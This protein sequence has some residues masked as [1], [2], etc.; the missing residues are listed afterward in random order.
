MLSEITPGSRIG[1]HRMRKDH[2]DNEWVTHCSRMDK[3][4]GKQNKIQNEFI[5]RYSKNKIFQNLIFL[6]GFLAQT[7]KP[8]S[9]NGRSSSG[10]Y[11]E[12]TGNG[13]KFNTP[14]R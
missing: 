11:S 5:K 9:F 13:A 10:I 1:W 2:P 12:S 14:I 6:P 8:V 4:K 7:A 3:E